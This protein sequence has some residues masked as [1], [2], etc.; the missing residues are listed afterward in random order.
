M[1]CFLKLYHARL[2]FVNNEKKE[3][4]APPLQTEGIIPLISNENPETVFFCLGSTIGEAI[5]QTISANASCG[6]PAKMCDVIS[7]EEPFDLT[8][9]PYTEKSIKESI[10]CVVLVV[11]NQ[12]LDTRQ[13]AHIASLV[14]HFL[15]NNLTV[16]I[17]LP[18]TERVEEKRSFSELISQSKGASRCAKS[19]RSA[20][21]IEHEKDLAS[22]HEPM[23]LILQKLTEKRE[24]SLIGVSSKESIEQRR[25]A[26]IAIYEKGEPVGRENVVAVNLWLRGISYIP[27][28]FRAAMLSHP[29]R[30]EQENQKAFTEE[31]K[32]TGLLSALKKEATLEDKIAAF[33]NQYWTI[34]SDVRW[35]SHKKLLLFSRLC[36]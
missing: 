4:P 3:V 5:K 22:L 35:K 20:T 14:S 16:K 23:Q 15:K 24:R 31:D 12:G 34:T 33:D 17:S 8:K 25:N 13:N 18:R 11:D 1:E 27:S 36:G 10:H 30:S 6:K 32:R 7:L 2:G 26:A 19:L 29:D 28:N 9:W 21:L